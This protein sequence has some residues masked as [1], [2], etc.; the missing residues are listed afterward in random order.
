MGPGVCGAASANQGWPGF[1]LAWLVV[2]FW[3]ALAADSGQTL[4][5]ISSHAKP[6]KRHLRFNKNNKSEKLNAFKSRIFGFKS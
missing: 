6:D 4:K 2:S 3:W 1:G 5:R